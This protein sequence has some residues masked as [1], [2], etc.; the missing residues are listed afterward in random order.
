MAVSITACW[1]SWIASNLEDAPRAVQNHEGRDE[2]AGVECFRDVVAK[3]LLC[4]VPSSTKQLKPVQAG[5][6]DLDDVILATQSQESL[7]A[8]RQSNGQKNSAPQ[9]ICIHEN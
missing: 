4:P 2:H 7:K 3:G 6:S 8:D 9:A 1:D 5:G